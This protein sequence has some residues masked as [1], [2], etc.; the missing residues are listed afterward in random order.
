[1][2][3]YLDGVAAESHRVGTTTVS[4]EEVGKT[5]FKTATTFD[6]SARRTMVVARFHCTWIMHTFD[7][8][9]RLI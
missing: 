3:A 7:L 5:K 6:S 4:G 1:M 8:A 2:G 9:P